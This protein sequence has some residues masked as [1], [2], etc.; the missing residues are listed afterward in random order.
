MCVESSERP[1][2]V[3]K[4]KNRSSEDNSFEEDS[5]YSSQQEK[6]RGP[7]ILT[8]EDADSEQEPLVHRADRVY[9][10]NSEDALSDEFITIYKKPPPPIEEK[11]IIKSK[12][13]YLRYLK[14]IKQKKQAR[15]QQ[16][17]VLK[18]SGA[19]EKDRQHVEDRHQYKL[20]NFVRGY[21]DWLRNIDSSEE[22]GYKE[23]QEEEVG[24]VVSAYETSEEDERVTRQKEKELAKNPLLI[25]SNVK[26]SGSG[27]VHVCDACLA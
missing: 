15:K 12:G 27:R 10:D 16:R 25:I 8:S 9:D 18:E 7:A 11:D 3:G 6:G 5:Q 22:E 4:R 23:E 1:L 19:I 13:H 24:A 14:A 2:L 26:I 21:F 20:E 17:K